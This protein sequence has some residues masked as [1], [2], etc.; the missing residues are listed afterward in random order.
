MK[1][2]LVKRAERRSMTVRK[3]PE[4]GMWELANPWRVIVHG[5]RDNIAAWL[6]AAE[7]H[8]RNRKLVVPQDY[9]ADH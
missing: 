1:D 8:D 5:T 6:D 7:S 2:E 9:S 4:I 3:A